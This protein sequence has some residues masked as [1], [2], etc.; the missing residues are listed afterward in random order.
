[1]VPQKSQ[2]DASVIHLPYCV[3]DFVSHDFCAEE[4]VACIVAVYALYP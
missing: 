1:M 4:A 2:N 3:A